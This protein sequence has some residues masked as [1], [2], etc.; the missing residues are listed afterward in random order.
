MTGYEA[1]KLY[2]PV[3]LHF[4]VESFDLFETPRVK[5]T[6][7]DYYNKRSDKF[8][9]EKLAKKFKQPRDCVRYYV[10]NFSY[11]CKNFLYDPVSGSENYLKWVS[12]SQAITQVFKDDLNLISSGALEGSI[13]VN[14][15]YD[16]LFLLYIN[17]NISHETL[18][19]LNS[20][21]GM[22]SRWNNPSFTMIWNDELLRLRK[23]SRFVKF[24]PDK[25][26]P[27]YDEWYEEINEIFSK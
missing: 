22:F 1:Y 13:K 26:K 17:G 18:V 21:N 2:I 20:F 7:V 19:I 15:S 23:S 14:E 8:L 12:K 3:K 11:G 4:T 6:G 24:N 27:V 16:D 10:A 25:I 9:F 5:H